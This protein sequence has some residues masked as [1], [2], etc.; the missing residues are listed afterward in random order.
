NIML[1][2]EFHTE[3]SEGITVT[4]SSVLTF[5][6]LTDWSSAQ[7]AITSESTLVT[8]GMGAISFT[9][10]AWSRIESRVFA[11][12][13]LAGVTNVLSFDVHIPDLPADFYW[14]GQMNAFVDCPSAGLW[15]TFVG[16]QPLQI[17]F[18]DEFNR[19]E[20]MLPDSVVDVLAGDYDDCR[21]A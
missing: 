11:T 13:E 3:G 14:L 17:L 20:Y 10:G 5:D 6:S 19:V 2:S 4:S 12:T 7:T 15:N 21:I 18:D 16:H 9:P 1:R 8:Q